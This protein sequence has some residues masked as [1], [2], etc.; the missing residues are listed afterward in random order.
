MHRFFCANA[1]FTLPAVLLCDAKE[2]HH[3]KEVLRLKKGNTIVIFNGQQEAEGTISAIQRLA[4][5]IKINRVRSPKSPPGPRLILACAIP[6][7]AKFEYIIEK[8]TELGVDEIIP[9]K[10]KRSEVVFNTQKGAKKQERFQAIAVNAAK[11][12]QRVQI[13]M[14]QPLTGLPEVLKRINPKKTKAFIPCLMGPREPLAKI[15]NIDP[16]VAEIM[17]FIGPEGDFTPDELNAAVQAGAL[18]VSLGPTTLKVDTA[19]ITVIALANLML[20]AK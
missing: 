11:Q 10:T 5:E 16:A 20:N 7:K 1:D 9:L 15:F 18:G 8:C 19:A 6:K 13:P 17:F 3:L 2:I 14:I 4:V 12:S